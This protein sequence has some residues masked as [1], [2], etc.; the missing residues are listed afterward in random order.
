MYSP[1]VQHTKTRLRI[2]YLGVDDGTSFHRAQALRRIGH[3]VEILDPWSFLPKNQLT[4]RVLDRLVFKGGAGVLEVYIRPL[5]SRAIE[6]RSY[7]VVWVDQGKLLGPSTVKRLKESAP[8]VINYNADDPFPSGD[9]N[10]RRFSL[11][12]KAVPAYDL[13][14]VVREENVTEAYAAGARR[15]LHTHMSADEVAHAPLP[16]TPE[17]EARWASD[18]S[19]IGGWMPERGPLLAKMLGLGV[20]LK[21]IGNRWVKAKEWPILKSA[22]AG[23]G[24]QGDNYVKA[25]QCA[26]VCIGL[27]SKG[28]R[29]LHTQRS[30]EVPYIG[31]VFCAE[32]TFEHEAMY[33]EGKEAVFW[34]TAEECAEKISWLL[35]NPEERLRIAKAGR[36]RCIKNGMLNEV[37]M[38]TILDAAMC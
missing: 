4:G 29:D 14:V 2:L 28:N 18:V 11:Y 17:D 15:V 22:W 3:D 10:K 12:R 33:E 23:P 35:E 25:I 30:A 31:T 5:L 8:F 16:L 7:D 36:E 9:P 21:I 20:P 24:L 32:R 19:F 37:I 26:K 38:G 27:L 34:S 1:A 6:G 13:V